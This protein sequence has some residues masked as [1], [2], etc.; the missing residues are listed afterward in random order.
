MK[1]IKVYNIG[2]LV[3]KNLPEKRIHGSDKLAIVEGA[4]GVLVFDNE[5]VGWKKDTINDT[6]EIGLTNIPEENSFFMFP[7][8]TADMQI[9][10]LL[11]AEY[12]EMTI[13]EFIDRYNYNNRLKRN[14]EII[15]ESFN[16]IGLDRKDIYKG[17]L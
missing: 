3:E 6:I 17:N 12:E 9:K 8:Y 13:T 11:K 2:E 1:K 4:N 5:A 10:D 15:L 16:E 14:F 7:Q